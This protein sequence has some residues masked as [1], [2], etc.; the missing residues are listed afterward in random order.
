MNSAFLKTLKAKKRRPRDPN[1]P[2]PPNLL[3]QAKELRIAKQGL[4][5]QEIELEIVKQRMD[6]MENRQRR[7]ESSAES[8]QNWVL[9]KLRK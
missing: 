7:L 5:R 3:S 8:F 9:T 1:A 6:H 2:A 4:D